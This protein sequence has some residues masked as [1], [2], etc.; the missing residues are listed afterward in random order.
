MV[1]WL[2]VYLVDIAR[3]G[4]ERLRRRAG[5][6]PPLVPFVGSACVA[7]LILFIP[8]HYPGLSLPLTVGGLSKSSWMCARPGLPPS[9]DTVHLSYGLRR[10][11]NRQRAC[12]R[13]GGPERD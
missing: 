12:W 11:L 13:R 6:W 3:R 9:I 8:T 1:A 5:L 2:F 10:W 4:F 7:L